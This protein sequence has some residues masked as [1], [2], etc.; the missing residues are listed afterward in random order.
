MLDI[1]THDIV[2]VGGGGAGLRAAIAISESNPKLSVAVVSKVYPMRSH[3]VAA[4]GGAAGVHI[5]EDS[6][7]RTRL[8]HHLRRR[9]AV[10]S[11]RCGSLRQGSSARVDAAGALGL[12]LEPGAR[13]TRRRAAFR[14][15]EKDAHLVCG[16][17]DRLPHAPHAVSNVAQIRRRHAV[18]RIFRHQTAGGRR[19][20]AGRGGDGAD[21]RQ[22]SGDYRQGRHLVHRRLWPRLPFHHQ[23]RH[24]VPAMAWRWP[25]ARALH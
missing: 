3:T 11:G 13:W 12:S 18:R 6:S 14:W 2:L 24:Q 9:L 20:R 21:H 19:P 1:S 23:R 22:D 5:A 8:R 4:E 16:R 25:I 17:Q 7:G 15:N 10:R